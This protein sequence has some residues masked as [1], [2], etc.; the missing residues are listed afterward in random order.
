MTRREFLKRA[1]LCAGAVA[2]GRLPRAHHRPLPTCDYRTLPAYRQGY[3]E[4]P[5]TL[6]DTSYM[7]PPSYQPPDLVSV[8]EAGFHS[9]QLIRAL[10]IADLAALR[11]AA[12]AAGVPLAIVSAYRS[13]A[14]QERV[15]AH[16]S[17]TLGLEQ[18]RL[19]S[20]RAGHSEH[21]LGTAIDFT[22]AGDPP[23]WEFDDWGETPAGAWLMANA[24]RFG[25]VLSYPRDSLERVCYIYE[26]W[27]Y[28]Y[29]GPER[30]AAVVASGLSLREWLWQHQ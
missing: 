5:Y 3:D 10:V 4:W 19:L 21:Q 1:A 14:H 15:F 26:P 17:R 28:R 25:F 9:N 29:L 6:V 18:A 24:H 2:L 30:A 11:Q 22:G 13:Y 23:P 16:W 12:A 27:H 20:A 8:A 7:L